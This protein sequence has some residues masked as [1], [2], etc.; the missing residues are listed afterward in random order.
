MKNTHTHT[1]SVYT[2][3]KKTLP[4]GK[5]HYIVTDA[6]GAVVS[7]RKSGRDYVACSACGYFYF[8]RL[9][10]IGKGEHGKTI[11]HA[12]NELQ[13]TEANYTWV[14]RYQVPQTFAEHQN[15]CQ[16]QLDRFY[17]IAYLQQ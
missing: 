3:T 5:F 11:A 6:N 13:V 12:L 14:G 1:Q 17:A 16:A 7:E 15:N 9:D 8:G 10:L 4:S 2:L